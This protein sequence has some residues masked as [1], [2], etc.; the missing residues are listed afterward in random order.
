MTH[1]ANG[2]IICNSFIIFVACK[3]NVFSSV[4]VGSKY[5]ANTLRQVVGFNECS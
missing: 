3:G 4:N 2:C 5:H 1:S